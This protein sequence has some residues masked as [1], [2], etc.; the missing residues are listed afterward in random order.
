MKKMSL[1]MVLVVSALSA[2]TTAAAFCSE[3]DVANKRNPC[4][5]WRTE[6]YDNAL[7]TMNAA[8]VHEQYRGQGTTVVQIETTIPWVEAIDSL[9][10]E[11]LFGDCGLPAGRRNDHIGYAPTGADCKIKWV[12]CFGTSRDGKTNCKFNPG[13][14]QGHATVVAQGIVKAAP[15]ANIVS[16]KLQGFN[17]PNYAAAVDWLLTPAADF[18]GKSPAE[19]WNVVAV[20]VSWGMLAVSPPELPGIKIRG[21]FSEY[22]EL[23]NPEPAKGPRPEKYVDDWE[24]THGRQFRRERFTGLQSHSQKLLDAGIPVLFAANNFLSLRERPR[25]SNEKFVALNGVGFPAC[26]RENF[27]VSG[28][29]H[30]YMYLRERPNRL[31]FISSNVHREMTTFVTPGGGAA[32]LAT[33][34]AS[35]AI[36]VLK[37]SGL[38]P[39]ADIEQLID[40]LRTSDNLP[41]P[42]GFSCAPDQGH[43][44]PGEPDA[45]RCPKEIPA[46]YLPVLDL[47]A[48]SAAAKSAH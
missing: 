31:R 6:L 17:G 18:A 7:V 33:P 45:F 20:N 14:R 4:K 32:S 24:R 34:L 44:P 48:A 16:L 37:S 36:A 3:A 40:W 9:S 46:Y 1:A 12:R 42:A 39:D 35:G 43:F 10:G 8:D 21:V 11:P 47:A 27:A 13:P 5:P 22:C 30:N 41:A 23:E 29:N 2:S 38:A 25:D 26:L 28:V 19:Y 15:D